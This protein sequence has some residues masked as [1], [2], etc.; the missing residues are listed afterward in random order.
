MKKQKIILMIV[1][2]TNMILWANSVDIE[3]HFAL[4]KGSEIRSIDSNI[5]KLGEKL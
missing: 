1:I 5:E 2:F 3:I 4:N